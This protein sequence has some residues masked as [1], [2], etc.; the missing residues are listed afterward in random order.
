[1]KNLLPYFLYTFLVFFIT[2]LS[3][4]SIVKKD[5]KYQKAVSYFEN[6]K[7]DKA[8]ET[9]Q[10]LLI[11]YE[12]YPEIWDAAIKFYLKRY[13][14]AYSAEDNQLAEQLMKS[15]SATNNKNKT[16]NISLS[17]DSKRYYQ[18]F[19]NIC[20]KSTLKTRQVVGSMYLRRALVDPPAD[21]SINKE[22]KNFLRQAEE[23]FHK[24]DYDNALKLYSKAIETQPDYYQ[25]I[26]Y[27]GDAYYFLKEYSTALTYFLKACELKPDLLEPRKYITD[28][29]TK[30][31]KYK[32]ASDACIEAI[33]VYPDETMFYKLEDITESLN[34]R[35]DKHWMSR[36]FINKAN[37][38]VQ[39]TTDSGSWKYYLEAKD[40]ILPYCDSTGVI[41]R[42]NDL[43]SQQY[44]EIYC[45]E[46]MLKNT[47][48]SKFDFAKKMM[49]ENHL[50]CY[51]FISLFHYGFYD[52]YKFFAKENKERIKAYIKN[53]LIY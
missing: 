19:L 12:E 30:S 45:W 15:L 5:K 22:A 18:D 27:K 7:V 52:Q 14:D 4:Q 29:L 38:K 44:L 11:K 23:S 6:N 31:G 41:I 21:T 13:S 35:F 36:S 28:A 25:A 39:Q 33:T 42:K 47:T 50:D 48:D 43:T 8:I 49:K 32:E 46:E 40:K 16:I 17:S 37:T 53:Y 1:M 34:K 10:P 9:I 3:A 51:V 2:D 26:L 24:K 20:Y